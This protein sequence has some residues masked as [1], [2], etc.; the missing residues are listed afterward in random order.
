MFRTIH[1]GRIG[2]PLAIG[3]AGVLMSLGAVAAA[4]A[5]W[6][7]P[8][9][10]TTPSAAP[11]QTCCNTTL[12]VTGPAAL[13]LAGQPVE[14]TEKIT[15][16]SAT[17]SQDLFLDLVADAG[18]GMPKNGLVM[19]Y[20]TDSGAWQKVLMEYSGGSFQGALPI[21]ITLGPGESRVLHLLLGLPMGEPH[22]G[23]S[24]GGAN[25]VQLTS[26]VGAADGSWVLQARDIR[27]I[28]VHGLAA[29][30]AGVPT[31]AVRGGAPVEF[32]ATLVNPTPSDYLNVNSVLFTDKYATVQVKRGG[33]WVTLP[34]VTAAAE[35]G[36]VGH[37][38]RERDHKVPAGSS[39]SVPVRV[40]W[41]ANAPLGK[42]TLTE[43]IIVNE[44]SVPF[45][46]THVGAAS[47]QVTLT[48]GQSA[49]PST[50]TGAGGSQTPTSTPS[51]S[52]STGTTATPTPAP[53][54]P[55]ASSPANTGTQLAST[56]GDGGTL[57]LSLGGAS[58]VFAGG[59]LA[60]YT[61]LR[62]RA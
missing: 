28:P 20:R 50:S 19:Y 26:S 55:P 23:D 8:G 29:G 43:S 60:A 49:S 16:T 44:G 36:L 15:N 31:T 37:Y 42:A 56:G 7:E 53:T 5:A 61:R 21:T 40:S 34:P 14:F 54:T 51:A 38:L 41:K 17:E 2:Q 45:R 39:G 1:I 24:D 32:D 52:A 11:A 12:S 30:L 46:G 47:A 10:P 22:N 9:A 59:S 35:P 62:R 13:G 3:A 4:P 18:A 58:L 27:T 25:S 33:A 6:A 57:A 48:G